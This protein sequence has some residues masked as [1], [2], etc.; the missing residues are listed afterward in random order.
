MKKRPEAPS[1]EQSV[2][3][4]LR[5]LV[6]MLAEKNVVHGIDYDRVSPILEEIGEIAELVGG[7]AMAKEVNAVQYFRRERERLRKASAEKAASELT[8]KDERPGDRTEWIKQDELDGINAYTYGREHTATNRNA[9]LRA[10][11]QEYRDIARQALERYGAMPDD[12]LL[13][14]EVEQAVEGVVSSWV[15]WQRNDL[16]AFSLAPGAYVVGPSAAA[17]ISK[18]SHDRAD[19]LRRKA[20]EGIQKAKNRFGKVL[21]R[22]SPRATSV[23][24]TG[25]SD[26]VE[27]LQK[28]IEAREKKQEVMKRANRILRKKGLSDSERI[29][30]VAK[31]PGFTQ[32]T[33]KVFL[34][35]DFAG[36]VGFAP[37]QLKNNNAEIRRLKQRLEAEKRVQTRSIDPIPFEL[38]GIEGRVIDNVDAN[39]VQI[40]FDDKPPADLRD[41]LKKRGFRWSRAEEAW[42]RQRTERGLY[43]ALV[44]VGLDPATALRSQV[45]SSEDAVSEGADEV[46][47]SSAE[48]VEASMVSAE[49]EARASMSKPASSESTSPAEAPSTVPDWF[50]DYRV[51]EDPFYFPRRFIQASKIAT[52]GRL[53]KGLKVYTSNGDEYEITRLWKHTAHMV[54]TSG[55]KVVSKLKRDSIERGVGRVSIAPKSAFQSMLE[56]YAPDAYKVFKSFQQERAKRLKSQPDDASTPQNP[57]LLAEHIEGG[58][59]YTVFD[60]GPTEERGRFVVRTFDE[61]TGEAFGPTSFSRVLTD[62]TERFET[63]AEQKKGQAGAQLRAARAEELERLPLVKQYGSFYSSFTLTQTR[64]RKSKNIET[65]ISTWKGPWEGKTVELEVK[66]IRTYNDSFATNAG[67]RLRTGGIR[68]DARAYQIKVSGLGKGEQAEA[69]ALKLAVWMQQ[70]DADENGAE[71]LTPLRVVLPSTPRGRG[72]WIEGLT[73]RYRADDWKPKQVE[74]RRAQLTEEVKKESAGKVFDVRLDSIHTDPARFQPRGH[75]YS[76]ESALRVARDFDPNLMEPV[77]LWH[78]QAREKDYVLAG[79]SRLQGFRW[80]RDGNADYAILPDATVERIPARYFDGDEEEAIRFA[81]V[82]N[83]KGTSLTNLERAGYLRTLRGAGESESAI[84]EESSKLYKRNGSTVYA[85]SFLNAAGKAATTLHQF[86]GNATGEARDAETMAVWV[87]KL[88]SRYMSAGFTDQHEREVY[89][90]LLANYKTRGRRFSSYNAFL[91]Y[92]RGFLESRMMMGQLEAGPIN[93]GQA[94]TKSPQERAVDEE[95]RRAE[96]DLSDAQ[97]SRDAA[98][99]NYAARAQGEELTRV[100]KPYND[101]VAVAQRDLLAIRQRARSAVAELGRTQPGLFQALRSNGR[102]KAPCV[103]C[104]ASPDEIGEALGH[105]AFLA[106]ADGLEMRRRRKSISVDLT[107]YVLAARPD[108][109]SLLLIPR[110]RIEGYPDAPGASAAEGDAYALYAEFHG[111]QGTPVAWAATLPATTSAPLVGVAET[112]YYRSPKII[113]RGDDGVRVNGYFH[114][115]DQDQRPVYAWHYPTGKRPAYVI[116]RTRVDGRGLIN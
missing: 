109:S 71:N 54:P 100:M 77:V 60:Y 92:V 59:R 91:D 17:G 106:D 39:R 25:E 95:V 9:R 104:T 5:K 72:Q 68:D 30:A 88:R 103:S 20:S 94:S 23:V 82:E 33:A 41:K 84:K 47:L 65:E 96:R 32:A 26:A 19:S 10:V 46:D 115:F 93:F 102:P 97:R 79:H 98:L 36:S 8:F 57:T 45:A 76:V 53:K 50:P 63:I 13:P 85:L 21:G 64:T 56:K 6:A 73:A 3:S 40:D 31:L 2:T 83:D 101:A 42:Q 12:G 52:W 66:P 14:D 29:E 110:E 27:Q 51:D 24:R 43:D 58:I 55:T 81:A 114:D 75:A 1:F 80:R 61:R 48:R 67:E 11:R 116:D 22:Y 15:T 70:S 62:A 4:I 108:G 7:S 113:E 89:D 99:R 112:I 49:E 28:K 105:I 111:Y 44:I 34:K 87:G 78:D 69:S 18:R 37:Y 38:D 90:L 74:E 107:G 16:K 35:K 86:Q